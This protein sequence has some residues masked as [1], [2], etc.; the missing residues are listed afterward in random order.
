MSD[1][2][3]LAPDAP[4]LSADEE[5]VL[6]PGVPLTA[7]QG[8]M[9]ALD[10]IAELENVRP[11]LGVDG[12]AALAESIRV[13]GLIHPVVL[14]PAPDWADHGRAYELIVG[15]RRVNAV[16]SLRD[17][18][19]EGYDHI[20]AKVHA[21]DEEQALAEMITE[22]LQREN[23]TPLAE[24]KAMRRMMDTFGWTQGQVAAHLGVHRT[25]VVKRLG[26]LK[27]AEPVQRYLEEGKITA[28]HAEVVARMDD[29][30]AQAELADLAVRTDASVQKLNAY[31]TKIKQAEIDAEEAV[32]TPAF[33][34]E[35]PLELAPEPGPV[36][37]LPR[38]QVREDLGEVDLA[39]AELFVL[40][41]AAN[42]LE[43]VRTLEDRYG[44]TRTDQWWWITQLSEA[45]VD[46]LRR[47]LLVRWLQA[48][49]RFPTLPDDLI[50]DLGEGQATGAPALL[51]S[52]DL[53]GADDDGY[54]D[55]D[56]D[57]LADEYGDDDF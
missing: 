40:L 18:G 57:E 32:E 7:P 45:Q 26:L 37:D 51:L 47:T 28:S 55:L 43:M 49:H 29:E 16:R 41:R 44:V 48:P 30:D 10:D 22:N 52:D 34:P 17:A 31:A 1:D 20:P 11:D 54:G 21:A 13:Q 24:A 39:R 2:Q 4:D 3:L 56:Y 46:E 53:P 38:L 33:G 27:L 12:V 6:L 9:I 35:Q 42:D 36:T 8:D 15:Y 23:L 19:L 25:Q 5:E 14:R 50:S